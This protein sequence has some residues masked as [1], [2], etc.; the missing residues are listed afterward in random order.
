MR[1][2]TPTT[3]SN[4]E[5]LAEAKKGL[6]KKLADGNG[7][8]I[9]N[10]KRKILE[11]EHDNLLNLFDEYDAKT[12]PCQLEQLNPA[13]A[14]A[15]KRDALKSLYDRDRTFLDNYW[16][17]ISKNSD[18]ELEYCPFCNHNA[19]TDLDHHIPRH[20]MPE[21]SV[22]LHNLIPT[23]HKCNND[24]HDDW[25][26][27]N[28]Q[29]IF[30]NAF[31]DVAPDITNVI[32]IVL[33]IDANTHTPKVRLS[34]KPIL[35]IDCINVKLAKTTIAKLELIHLY[36]QMDANDITRDLSSR[37]LSR[38]KVKK[39]KGVVDPDELWEEEKA[40]LEEEILDMS[41]FDIIK[42]AIYNQ[43]IRTQDFETWVKEQCA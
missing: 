42:K 13:Y 27:A 35:A 37:F 20:E 21:Y 29:R 19:V 38:I 17:V 2:L 11:D 39:R 33:S 3:Y 24:K 6:H 28:G 41:S 40:V 36:W 8:E 22:C 10:P 14:D 12:N 4:T 23:C 15:E 31:Y 9:D 43:A 32:E 26:D 18:G 1:N 30:F 5:L 25:L 34:V 16:N 7:N